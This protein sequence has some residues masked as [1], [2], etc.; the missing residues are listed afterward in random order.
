M[1]CGAGVEDGPMF[2]G[3]GVSI[4][5][6]EEGCGC[7]S[8]VVDGVRKSRQIKDNIGAKFTVTVRP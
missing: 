4:D 8:I 3:L 5:G 1:T 7:K 2:D 6:L